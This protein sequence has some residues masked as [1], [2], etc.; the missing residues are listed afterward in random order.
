MMGAGFGVGCSYSN[1]KRVPI[2]IPRLRMGKLRL[3]EV[4]EFVQEKSHAKLG[5][6]LGC[7]IPKS[8]LNCYITS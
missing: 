8:V 2:I 1:L 3:G 4:E 7:Q 5:F 6:L